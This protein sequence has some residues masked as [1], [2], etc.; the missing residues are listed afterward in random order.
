MN[1]LYKVIAKAIRMS[2]LKNRYNT[3]EVVDKNELV[4]MLSNY[5]K[6]TDT[7]FNSDEFTKACAYEKEGQ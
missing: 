1:T 3:T 5:F 4:E 2:T 7:L 6:K